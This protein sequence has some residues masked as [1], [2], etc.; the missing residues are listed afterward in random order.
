MKPLPN[1]EAI[2]RRIELNSKRA[3]LSPLGELLIEIVGELR[4][5]KPLLGSPHFSAILE[6][7]RNDARQ[8]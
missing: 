6:V 2:A 4:F 3:D 1:R 7:L 5:P 8:A